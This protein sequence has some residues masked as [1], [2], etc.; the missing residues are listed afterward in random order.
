MPARDR[1]SRPVVEAEAARPS[2]SQ[3]KREAH[4]LQALGEALAELP[5]DRLDAL[6]L[7]E[8]LLDAVR[9][10]Q[11]TRSHEGRRRQMQFIGRL[12]RSAP[13]EP[14]REAVLGV[15]LGRAQEALALHRLERWREELV[16]DDMAIERFA[17]EFASVDLQVLR[18]L[19]RS[20]RREA[21]PVVDRHGA[22]SRE[23]P[24]LAERRGRAWRELFQFIK[25]QQ[26]GRAA[27]TPPNEPPS[28]EGGGE[29]DP[30][31]SEGV[32]R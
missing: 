8:T 29:R 25:Q 4:D 5:A 16:A 2:K 19:V 12:M 27:G 15:R 28:D 17:R 9:E 1:A 3:L 20:A 11:R 13:I 6:P 7:P 23:R 18:S 26:A 21:A 10:F 32:R 31:R 14:I 22:T 30:D 24:G